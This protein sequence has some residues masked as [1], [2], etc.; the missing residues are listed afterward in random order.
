MPY[1]AVRMYIGTTAG[2]YRFQA[3]LVW[4]TTRINTGSTT[5]RGTTEATGY[6]KNS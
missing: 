2:R 6:P 3:D 5:P 4:M 1:R